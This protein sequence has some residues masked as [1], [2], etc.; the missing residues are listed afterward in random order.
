MRRKTVLIVLSVALPVLL[1]AA[2][3]VPCIVDSP[4]KARERILRQDVSE[5]RA[6][7]NQYTLDLQRRPQSIDD[8]VTAG[9]LKH[10]PTDPTT[11]R[12]DTWVVE[13]SNDP[14]MPGIV[15]I[16]SGSGRR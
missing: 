10:I 11:G 12:S 3:I 16:R 14:E 13:R 8:L 1:A 5:F 9:Y 6:L 2:V 4:E 15:G 7:I